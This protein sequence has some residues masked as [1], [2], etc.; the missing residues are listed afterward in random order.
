MATS[1]AHQSVLSCSSSEATRPYRRQVCGL[2]VLLA[3]FACLGTSVGLDAEAQPTTLRLIDQ[4]SEPGAGTVPG[5]TLS[6]GARVAVIARE[7]GKA[8]ALSSLNFRREDVERRIR[9]GSA[10]TFRL[11]GGER[12]PYLFRQTE[13]SNTVYY[14][15][16]LTQEGKLLESYVNA[17]N[18]GYLPGFTIVVSGDLVMGPVPEEHRGSLREALMS[19]MSPMAADSVAGRQAEGNSVTEASPGKKQEKRSGAKNGGSGRGDEGGYVQMFLGA[20]SSWYG[21]LVLGLLIGGGGTWMVLYRK[22]RAKLSNRQR[23]ELTRFSG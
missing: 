14:V 18:R 11:T 17:G 4:V 9:E 10:E 3:A 5:D 19:A 13:A 16:A 23:M 21:A 12:T 15:L 2:T 20:L 22:F 7:G 8:Y 1:N 6:S